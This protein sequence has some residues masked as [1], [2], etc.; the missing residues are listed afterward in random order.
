[1]V[2]QLGGFR[3]R[4]K[5]L[6]GDKVS[7]EK[8]GWRCHPNLNAEQLMSLGML[9]GRDNTRFNAGDKE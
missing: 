2:D 7:P 4:S 6:I 3:E 5:G 9:A 8:I 1:M